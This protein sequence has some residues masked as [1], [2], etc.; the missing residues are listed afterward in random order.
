MAIRKIIYKKEIETMSI[1]LVDGNNI[2][3]YNVVL[4]SN[5]NSNLILLR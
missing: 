3:L 4:V 2:K 1:P 5:Y